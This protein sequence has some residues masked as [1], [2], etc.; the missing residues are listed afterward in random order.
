M[1]TTGLPIFDTTIQKTNEWL[2][3]LMNELDIQNRKAAYQILRAVL[4]ALRDRL[5]VEEASDL[6]AGMPLLVRGI[7]FEGW[8]PGRKREFER[9]E[10]AFL[11]EVMSQFGGRP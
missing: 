4:H 8:N 6:A 11:N 3:D 10:E 9:T 7:F 5:T 2:N 1:S